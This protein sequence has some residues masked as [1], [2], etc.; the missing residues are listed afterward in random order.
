[1]LRVN[2]GSACVFPSCLLGSLQDGKGEV[3][4]NAGVG[5]EDIWGAPKIY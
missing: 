3:I 5:A 1:M 2:S 4:I